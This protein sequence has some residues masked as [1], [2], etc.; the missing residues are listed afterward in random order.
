M[1]T[2]VLEQK[3]EI[4]QSKKCPFCAE[5][6][7]PEAIKCRFCGEFLDRRPSAGPSKWYYSTSTLVMAVLFVGPLA[8]PLVWLNP[9][10]KHATKLAITIAVIGLTIVAVYAMCD[11]YLKLTEQLK[12][13]GL[14]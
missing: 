14:G 6:I 13:L 10:Y 9:R 7:Q 12:A 2:M 3:T 11:A 1:E 4:Q 5:Q 8:L